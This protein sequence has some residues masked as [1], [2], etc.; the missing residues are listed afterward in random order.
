M[1]SEIGIDVQGVSKDFGSFRALDA[2]TLQVPRGEIFGLLGP[3]GS[4]KSTLIRILC[5]LLAPTEGHA[6]VDGLDV[7]R[8]GELV[9][10]H[11]GYVSQSFSLYRDLTVQENLDFFSSIYRL[12]R[13][14]RKERIEWAI[15]L[16]H[17]GP[18]RDRLA[19]QLSGGWKQ[20]LALAAA[21]MHRPPVLFLDEP[22][23]GIDPV[24]RRELW[25]LL[26]QL[27][28]Q[29]V[30][31]FV[32]TH[33]MDEAERCGTVAYLYMSRLIVSGRPEALKQLPE[34]TPEGM[35]RVEAVATESI[36]T[37]LTKA[38]TLRYIRACTIFGTSLHLLIDANVSNERVE[39]D[40]EAFGIS[41]VAVHDIEASLE[42]V[43][44]RLTE[45]R[46]R[47]IEAQRATM[48]SQEVA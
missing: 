11:I 13:D 1:S 18:Y 44:V 43:F 47:E 22:T 29:G 15:D 2:V 38:K 20:R 5:G 26:F 32:T 24:A 23:A 12:N 36:A 35:R 41:D 27:A 33:Y 4:G 19:A 31:M 8:E 45:T 7:E 46:G 37:L 17:I 25:D 30:T 48:V 40:L 6:K 34:V 28:G 14:E 3:N 21:L 16:T 9:R 39:H 42:D 10:Q